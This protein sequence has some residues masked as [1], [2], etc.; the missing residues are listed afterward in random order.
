M[1]A[2]GAPLDPPEDGDVS[3]GAGAQGR[4]IAA[5]ARRIRGNQP[6]PARPP[7]PSDEVTGTRTPPL[8]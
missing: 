1:Q 7:E 4:Q 2:R 3:P 6:R 8:R 5:A